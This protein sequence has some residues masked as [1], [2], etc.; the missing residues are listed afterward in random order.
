VLAAL[1]WLPNDIVAVGSSGWDRWQGGNSI[2][3]GADP[4]IA[5]LSPDGARSATRVIPLS[6]GGRHFTLHD[7]VVTGG[8]IVA[9][10]FSDAPMTHSADGGNDAARTFGPMRLRLAR[11]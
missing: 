9:H 10:G 5:W 1:R 7:V 2:S 4:L 3:R 11:P 8:A 6:D